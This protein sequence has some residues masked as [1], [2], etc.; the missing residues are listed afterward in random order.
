MRMLTISSAF[1]AL[2]SAF[3]VY[4]L[5]YDTRILEAQVTAQE[6]A[7]DKARSDIAI[8]KADRALLSHPER[9]EPLARA[10]GMVPLE[11]IEATDPA[12]AAAV[13]AGPGAPSSS[14]TGSVHV[15]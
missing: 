5:N 4:G 13:A 6:Q 11:G 3:L 14:E 9:I 1:F 2:A 8:L 15:D 12:E 10:D 7:A